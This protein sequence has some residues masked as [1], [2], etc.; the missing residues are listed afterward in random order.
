MAFTWKN[1]K[2]KILGQKGLLSIGF[3][4]IVGSG[5]TAMFWLYIASLLDPAIYGEII[6]FIG[7]ASLVQL[8]ASIGSVNVITVYTSK[9]IKIQST[10]FLINLVATAVSLCVL[11]LVL[12]RIDTAFLAIGYIMFSMVNSVLLGKKYFVKYGKIIL[13]QKILTVT[14]GLGFYFGFDADGIIYGLALSY[15][16][17]LIIFIKEF[18]MTKI[19]FSSKN[20]DFSWKKPIFIRFLDFSSKIS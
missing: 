8:V 3:A 15:L 2:E 7:I 11:T 1:F 5:I 19:D 18:R 20:R 13:L 17:H 14:F 6:Y 16:P 10:L 12:N 4:D 9:G